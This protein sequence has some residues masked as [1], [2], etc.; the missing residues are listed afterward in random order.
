MVAVAIGCLALVAAMVALVF[1]SV[2]WARSS[3][4]RLSAGDAERQALRQR[5]DALTA[6]VQARDHAIQNKSTEL[7]LER[8]ARSAVQRQRDDALATIE[9]LAAK[10]PAATA[11]AMRAQL[12][13]LRALPVVPDVPEASGSAPTTAADPG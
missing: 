3:L 10:S 2:R 6:D 9:K 8:G 12:E 4:E 13:R 5:V 1:W 11:A 7:E